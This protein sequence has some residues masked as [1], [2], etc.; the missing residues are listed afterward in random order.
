VLWTVQPT[1]FQRETT[2][3]GRCCSTAVQAFADVHETAFPPAVT[4]VIDHRAWFLISA[5]PGPT[6]V[7]TLAVG[8]DT[9]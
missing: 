8:H 9:P 3:A 4:V 7:Q 1:P 6:A 5:I 2:G